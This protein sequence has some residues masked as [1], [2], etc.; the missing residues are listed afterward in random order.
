MEAATAEPKPPLRWWMPLLGLLMV[1]TAATIVFSILVGATG[2]S[3]KHPGPTVNLIA[4][5]LQDG[6]FVGAAVGLAGS[7]VSPSRGLFG[8]RATPL[9]RAAWVVVGSYL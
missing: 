7:V 3:S 5:F 4:T 1:L 6:L 9:R 8:L 2:A